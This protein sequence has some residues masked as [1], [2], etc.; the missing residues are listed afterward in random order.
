MHDFIHNY[1]HEWFP[2]LPG[3]QTFVFRLNQL[4]ATF[5]TVGGVLSQ[6][7]ATA[8]M[9]EVDQI[10]DSMPARVGTTWTFLFC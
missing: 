6:F 1:W 7:L 3:Y 4:E 2:H 9:P 8:E 10:V 5:Q